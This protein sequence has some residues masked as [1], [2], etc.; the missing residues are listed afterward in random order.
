MENV[1]FEVAI[2]GKVQKFNSFPKAKEEYD[3]LKAE[4]NWEA[5]LRMVVE[6]AKP[7]YWNDRSAAFIA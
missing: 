3:N 4:G 5:V 6:G 2:E 1:R 7:L